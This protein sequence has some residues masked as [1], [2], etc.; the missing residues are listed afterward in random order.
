MEN[1]DRVYVAMANANDG[2][3]WG[4]IPK[5]LPDLDKERE[6]L[7]EEL[8]SAGQIKSHRKVQLVPSMIGE[9]FMGDQFF[10]DGKAYIISL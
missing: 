6:Y 7:F 4:I 2:F 8:N 5:I 1:G 10:T 9:N 3:K